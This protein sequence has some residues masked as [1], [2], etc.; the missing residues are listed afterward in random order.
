MTARGELDYIRYTEVFVYCLCVVFPV[1]IC[2]TR[3]G[4]LKHSPDSV[5]STDTAQSDNGPPW[6]VYNTTTVTFWRHEGKTGP[7]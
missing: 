7:M 6:Q 4:V 5:F 3:L 2:G 1:L